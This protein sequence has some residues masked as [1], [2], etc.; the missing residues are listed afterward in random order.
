MNFKKE[1]EM[2]RKV[3]KETKEVVKTEIKH[4][5]YTEIFAFKIPMAESLKK[6]GQ[7]ELKFSNLGAAGYFTRKEL[8]EYITDTVALSMKSMF[9]ECDVFFKT[10]MTEV[11]L[12]DITLVFSVYPMRGGEKH[13]RRY[14]YNFL[15]KRSEDISG[16]LAKPLYDYESKAQ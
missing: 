16:S 9:V 7:A 2:N 3:M 6:T 15:T 14:K 4:K 5:I 11:G 1:Y 13:T 12:D 8:G 10:Q